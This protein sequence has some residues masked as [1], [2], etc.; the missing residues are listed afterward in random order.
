MF[1][2]TVDNIQA[3]GISKIIRTHKYITASAV[4]YP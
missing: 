4:I 3:V 1:V 2:G